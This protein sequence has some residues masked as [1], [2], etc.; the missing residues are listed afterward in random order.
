MY[1]AAPVTHEV[2]SWIFVEE[3]F[4]VRI[5]GVSLNMIKRCWDGELCGFG[6]SRYSYTRGRR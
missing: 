6:L 3:S 4:G 2:C 1:A 5:L